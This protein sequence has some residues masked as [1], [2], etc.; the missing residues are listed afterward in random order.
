M[1]ELLG[2]IKECESRLKFLVRTNPVPTPKI[3]TEISELESRL[4]SLTIHL[5][6]AY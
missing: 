6:V 1:R 5:M 4:K 2:A 3:Q